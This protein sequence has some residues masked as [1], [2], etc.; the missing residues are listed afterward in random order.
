MKKLKLIIVVMLLVL[1][2]HLNITITKGEENDIFE[3][4]PITKEYLNSDKKEEVTPPLVRAERENTIVSEIDSYSELITNANASSTFLLKNN[5]G[6]NLLSVKNQGTSKICWAFAGTSVLESNLR[7]INNNYNTYNPYHMNNALAFTYSNAY[8][9]Y[10]NRNNNDGGNF[11]HDMLYWTSNLGPVTSFQNSVTLRP[12]ANTMLTPDNVSID[13][14]YLL[15]MFYNSS[16]SSTEKAAFR[17]ELKTL[18]QN[19]GAVYIHAAAPQ[20]EYF[21]ETYDSVYTTTVNSYNDNPHAMVI[22]GWDDNFS[23][24]KFNKSSGDYPSIDGAWI[25]QNSWGTAYGNSGYYY[26]SYEDYMIGL[27]ASGIISTSEKVY[28]NTYQYNPTGEL[29]YINAK[30]L[31]NV[32]H[33]INDKKEAITSVGIF[34][35]APNTKVNVYIN[36]KDSSIENAIKVNSEPISI[37]YAGYYTY[38]LDD[39]MDILGSDFVVVVEYLTYNVNSQ[40][41]KYSVPIHLKTHTTL[42]KEQIGILPKQSYASVNN[43]TWL[44]LYNYDYSGAL[45]VHTTNVGSNSTSIETFIK[46]PVLKSTD[47]TVYLN[48]YTNN[49]SNASSITY[50]VYDQLGK[51]VT[52][53]FTIYD[54]KVVNNY[55]IGILTSTK[56]IEDGSYTVIASNGNYKSS[57]IFIVGDGYKTNLLYDNAIVGVNHSRDLSSY[58]DSYETLTWTSSNKNVATVNNGVVTGISEGTANIIINNTYIIKVT[59]KNPIYISSANEFLNIN[60]DLDEYYVLNNDIDFKNINYS[61]IGSDEKPFTGIINGNN[62][63]IKN[64]EYSSDNYSSVIGYIKGGAVTNI[65]FDNINIT[66]K[67]YVGVIGNLS[68]GSVDNIYLHNSII[69]GV[70]Y[71]GVI[72]YSNGSVISN[73]FNTSTIKGKNYVGGIIG[74]ANLSHIKTSYNKGIITGESNIGGINGLSY[75]SRINEVY[76]SSN[77]TGTSKNVGGIVGSSNTS[78][79]KDSYNLG[80]INGTISGGIVGELINSNSTTFKN[81]YNLGLI[82]GTIKGGIIGYGVVT[83]KTIT[84]S[85]NYDISDS[86]PVFG[87]ININY[88]NSKE[89]S[90]TDMK[91]SSKY[92][93]FDFTNI[94]EMNGYPVLKNI[95]DPTNIIL[96]NTSYTINVGE[97]IKLDATIVSNGVNKIAIYSLDNENLNIDG[98][99]LVANSVGNTTVTVSTTNNLIKTFTVKVVNVVETNEYS[100]ENGYILGIDE[101]TDYKALLNNLSADKVSLYKNDELVNDENSIIGT[102]MKIKVSNGSSELTYVVIV[103]GDITGDG[104]VKMNDIT[105]IATY[106]VEGTGVS[107]NNLI[108][109]DVTNDSNVKM[110]DITTIARYLVEGGE[111]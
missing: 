77:V 12:M 60:N 32:Y 42:T 6:G 62:Y 28:D 63:R 58:I 43:S 26:Y 90:S 110:N 109:G 102:N 49:I 75:Y 3:L 18:I 108:A 61:K 48:T 89:L 46:N 51:D 105:T 86:V 80:I 100:L 27:F 76:N 38:Y 68:Y 95:I 107:K 34:S 10:G 45:K 22:V 39:Y 8:N 29:T 25:V 31:A 74:Y 57:K 83:N 23:R 11:E 99:Y 64:I 96:S 67:N 24:Y 13:N 54:S 9:I 91:N 50:K 33:K 56:T 44:D 65:G 5:D 52:S 17:N 36:T 93:E 14:I 37:H 85:N 66:G 101:K 73:S 20:T 2:C 79:I 21:N 15:D 40:T 41:Y 106:L 53:N 35:Y 81:T 94:W 84:L 4:A 1:L 59:V 98:D 16:A 19:Y 88:V 70:D 30:Y 87:N 103:R 111:L 82:N 47:K 69:N 97:K 7:M 55:S 72:G 104:L 71:V 92:I 78:N